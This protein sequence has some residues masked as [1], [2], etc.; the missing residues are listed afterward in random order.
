MKSL[1]KSTP[2]T[3]SVFAYFGGVGDGEGAALAFEFAFALPVPV[4][5]LVFM[6]LLVLALALAFFRP[7]RA[8]RGMFGSGIGPADG[9]TTVGADAGLLV[10]SAAAAGAA[11]RRA[12]RLRRERATAAD[13]MNEHCGP[14]EIGLKVRRSPFLRPLNEMIFG[15]VAAAWAIPGVAGVASPNCITTAV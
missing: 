14:P 8:L 7:V 1:R 3:S 12:P 9:S 2:A 15:V 4:F 5:S 11:N 13:G 6:L 10:L